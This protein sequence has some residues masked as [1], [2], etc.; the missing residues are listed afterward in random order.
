MTEREGKIVV[1]GRRG[2]RSDNLLYGLKEKRGYCKLKEEE[3]AS[4]L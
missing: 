1:N 4:T 2:R 3:L